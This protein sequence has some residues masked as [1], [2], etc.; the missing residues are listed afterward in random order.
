VGD[1]AIGPSGVVK[2]CHTWDH[3]RYC[4][5]VAAEISRFAEAVDGADPTAPVPTCPEWT[6]GDLTLHLGGVH[7]WAGQMVRDVAQERL[8]NRRVEMGLDE[9]EPAGAA[10][11]TRGG[12]SLVAVLRDADPDAPMWAWGA[13]Q[14]A[15][16]WARRMLHETTIHRADAEFAVGREPSVGGEVAVDGIDEFLDN[17]PTARRFAPRVAELAGDEGAMAWVATDRPVRWRI[18]LEPGGF[19]WSH[20]DGPVDASVSGPAADLLLLAYGRRTAGDPARFSVTGDADLVAWWQE[21]SP[22]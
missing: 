1:L 13:D 17:L 7:R 11:I 22:I 15:R 18:E 2:T 20:G 10:W 3:D 5:A 21:R 4:E 6:V 12:E 9:D 16:F 19:A 8:S 14:H